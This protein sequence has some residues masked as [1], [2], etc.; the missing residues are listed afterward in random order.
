MADRWADKGTRWT[1]LRQRPVFTWTASGIAHRST[2]SKVVRTRAR[3]MAARLQIHE[4]ENPTAKFLKREGNCRLV[5]G[6]TWKDKQV[7]FRAKR[8][9]LQS[10]SFQFQCAANFK[11]WGWQESEECRL[12]KFL[13][14]EQPAF[15][16]C[17]GHI[18]GYCKA[19]QKPSL[20]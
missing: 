18:Q 5:L 12:C 15:A 2:M 14:P 3:V 6:D 1:S 4:H 20:G 16:E 10:I 19:L 11:K 17:L 13:Y 9:L 7:S 8:R